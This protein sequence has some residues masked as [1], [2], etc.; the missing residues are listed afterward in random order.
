MPPPSA[1]T[2]VSQTDCKDMTTQCSSLQPYAAVSQLPKAASRAIKGNWQAASV[3]PALLIS[4]RQA[5]LGGSSQVSQSARSISLQKCCWT[6][7]AC[8]LVKL[9]DLARSV[10]KK[11]QTFFSV[12]LGLC[13]ALVLERAV[14]V[15]GLPGTSFAASAYLT[16]RSNFSHQTYRIEPYYGPGVSRV[17]RIRVS[18]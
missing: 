10:S 5:R 14:V 16:S 11:R 8:G 18:P 7:R 6:W 13:H 12:R 9:S 15:V 3:Q 17:E 1:L 4:P 2:H